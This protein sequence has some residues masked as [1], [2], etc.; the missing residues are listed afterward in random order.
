[1]CLASDAK[2]MHI[3]YG[4]GTLRTFDAAEFQD[5]MEARQT[6]AATLGGLRLAAC[7][8]A[9]SGTVAAIG[10]WDNSIYLYSLEFGSV[11]AHESEAHES[12]VSQLAMQVRPPPP[13][14][15]PRP[16]VTAPDGATSSQQLR[17]RRATCWFRPRGTA[18]SKCGVWTRPA[19]S[20]PSGS[21]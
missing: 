21:S 11:L 20:C 5:G 6:K 4:D 19:T 3:A 13:H 12:A 10:S 17:C 14:G 8:L 2:A 1:M 7:C 16:R 9:G 15:P 18:R